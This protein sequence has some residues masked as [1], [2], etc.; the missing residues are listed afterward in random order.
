MTLRVYDDA[1]DATTR[2]GWLD[3]GESAHWLA[4]ADEE[5]SA[6]EAERVTRWIYEREGVPVGYGELLR[7]EADGYTRLMRVV[8]DP[9]HRRQGLG[10]GLVRALVE[11][12]RALAQGEAVYARID[13][14]NLPALLA[15]PSAGLV[16][17]DPLPDGFDE[18]WVWLTTSEDEPTVPGGA[19]GD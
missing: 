13:P 12:A 9:V 11:R 1:H 6:T 17:L 5:L 7:G 2:R 14:G 19:L 15:Y 8:V 3:D 4:G 16:P 18:R 10:A